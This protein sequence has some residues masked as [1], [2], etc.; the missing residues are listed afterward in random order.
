M[1]LKR[2]LLSILAVFVVFPHISLAEAKSGIEQVMVIDDFERANHSGLY[3]WG[4]GED[5]KVV[6]TSAKDVGQKGRY[7][8]KIDYAIYTNNWEEN[9]TS[10]SRSF[11]IPQDFSEADGISLWV[12]GSG[13]GGEF[14]LAIRDIQGK[15]LE[16]SNP[17]VLNYAKWSRILIPFNFLNTSRKLQ[18]GKDVNFDFSNVTNIEFS[19]GIPD[20]ATREVPIKGSCFIDQLE[21]VE[22]LFTI[23]A[24]IFSNI[25]DGYAV[26]EFYSDPETG[27]G[28]YQTINFV[29]TFYFNDKV[30]LHWNISLPSRLVLSG[31]EISREIEWIRGDDIRLVNTENITI[32]LS[33]L[34]LLY[35]NPIRYVNDLRIGTNFLNWNPWVL[36]SQSRNMGILVRGTIGKAGDYE[37]FFGIDH[38]RRVYMFGTRFISKVRD[39]ITVMPMF[40]FGQQQAKIKNQSGGSRPLADYLISGINVKAKLAEGIRAN[41]T[42]SEMLE[43]TYGIWKQENPWDEGLDYGKNL[44]NALKGGVIFVEEFDRPLTISDRAIIGNISVDRVMKEHPI[45]LVFEG[46][47]IGENFGGRL[48]SDSLMP[49]MTKDAPNLLHI[50]RRTGVSFLQKRYRHVTGSGFVDQA[51]VNLRVFYNKG[52]RIEGWIEGDYSWR[53]SNSDIRETRAE[54]GISYTERAVKIIGLIGK[55]NTKEKDL[56]INDLFY[57]EVG[58]RIKPMVSLNL[59]IAAGHRNEEWEVFSPMTRTINFGQLIFNPLPNLTLDFRIKRSSPEIGEYGGSI[60]EVREGDFR[61]WADQFP[62]YFTQ[63]VIRMDF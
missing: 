23:K 62:D 27:S 16:Y 9:W 53:V 6:V 24:P 56:L 21:L 59:E 32:A 34:Y 19:I 22:G 33:E 39:N 8:M 38:W 54:V 10:I 43:N 55:E 17:I 51:G 5:S 46:R 49:W 1:I 47:Y 12:K 3:W 7:A 60:G 18:K 52:Q 35:K 26:T 31:Y 25:P 41:F 4:S 29:D 63:L 40:V 44:G 13:G 20:R 36:H 2:I 45:S 57:Y 30:S 15:T 61:D 42:Y 37:S 50:E 28:W 58:I 48:L 11:A 14:G